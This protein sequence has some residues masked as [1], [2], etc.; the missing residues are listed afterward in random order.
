M[1][2][3]RWDA[4]VPAPD[5]YRIFSR[6]SDQ[7]YDYTDAFWE[8]TSTSCTLTGL[9]EGVTY[10]FVVRAYVG[11]LESAD[12]DEVEYTPPKPPNLSPVADAGKRQEVEEG[13][14]V[15]LDGSGSTDAGRGN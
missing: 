12:S 1:S 15:T 7:P 5:G 9:V 10:H 14:R 13:D 2:P 6:Q 8:G 11:D 3:L 4:N